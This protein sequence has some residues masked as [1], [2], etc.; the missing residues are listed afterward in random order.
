MYLIFG[1]VYIMGHIH[2]RILA[3]A[4]FFCLFDFGWYRIILEVSHVN[5]IY[6]RWRGITD[7]TI[8]I[9]T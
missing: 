9:N 6:R 2:T 3:I 1:L 8:Q 4:V 7:T 5:Y